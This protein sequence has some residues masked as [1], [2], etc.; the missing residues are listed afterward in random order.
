MVSLDEF[1]VAYLG[2]L[3]LTFVES[4]AK[5]RHVAIHSERV[6]AE[7]LLQKVQ[8]A[9][10]HVHILSDHAT[11]KTMSEVGRQVESLVKELERNKDMLKLRMVIA[12][13]AFDA[14]RVDI[15]HICFIQRA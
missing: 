6:T 10:W 15:D 8:D 12:K 11:V 2:E 4:V 9:E 3:L 5:A 13:K 1:R 14:T 7:G